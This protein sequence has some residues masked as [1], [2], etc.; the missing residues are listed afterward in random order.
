MNAK[1]VLGSQGEQLA[2]DYLQQAG[3][4]I[5]DRNWR[6]DEGEIDIVAA[7]SRVLVIC[8]VKTRRAPGTGRRWRPSTGA[9]APGCGGWPS[10]GWSRT[11]CSSTKCASTW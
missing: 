1:D 3:L 9:S 5:L 7:D 4:R 8:E 10:G 11:D 2:V 6:C